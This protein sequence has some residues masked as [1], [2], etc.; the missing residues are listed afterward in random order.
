RFLPPTPRIVLGLVLESLLSGRDEAEI[1][2][3]L[4]IPNILLGKLCLWSLV[5]QDHPFG[6]ETW[7][8]HFYPQL[9]TSHSNNWPQ[10]EKAP[11]RFRIFS[12]NGS[13]AI[14]TLAVRSCCRSA[15]L[16]N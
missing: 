4:G 7:R 16:E 15:C 6:L 11:R 2:R 10:P 14:S 8:R 9:E 3:P 5:S 13:L 12:K 1:L